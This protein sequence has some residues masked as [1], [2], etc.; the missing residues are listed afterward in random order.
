MFHRL[1]HKEYNSEALY[2]NE[3]LINKISPDNPTHQRLLIPLIELYE[4]SQLPKTT[5]ESCDLYLKYY[6][7]KLD[8]TD[9]FDTPCLII[10]RAAF[11]V[12]RYKQAFLYYK[13]A[14]QRFVPIPSFKIFIESD[15]RFE[16]LY[17]TM[18][19]AFKA[20]IFK[21]VLQ[22]MKD[23]L[24][25][26]TMGNLNAN[27]PRVLS[28]HQLRLFQIKLEKSEEVSAQ[29]TFTKFNI[30]FH[31]GKICQLKGQTLMQFS[32]LTTYA[33][34]LGKADEI[35][36]E[37]LDLGKHLSKNVREKLVEEILVRKIV[38]LALI[39]K[40]K[41]ALSYFQDLKKLFIEPDIYY[42]LQAERDHVNRRLIFDL[43]KLVTIS[44]ECDRLRYTVYKNSLYICDHFRINNEYILL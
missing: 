1:L 23:H 5:I 44:A 27:N 28:M 6:R 4:Y 19:A 2:W 24:V 36:T 22:T 18:E 40:T 29:R 41:K 34:W 32:S 42:F 25:P 14:W 33:H 43:M 30:F 15:K 39:K 10:A 21:D 17:K 7:S 20:K 12:K 37:L 11:K 35:F 3:N 38:M 26:N 13:E 9:G 16:Y 31:I 8:I